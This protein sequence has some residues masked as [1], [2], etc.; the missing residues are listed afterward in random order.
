MLPDRSK[1]YAGVDGEIPRLHLATNW[2]L[3]GVA[4]LVLVFLAAIFPRQALLERLYQ[5]H[6]LDDLTLSYV[7][8]FYRTERGNADTI[9]LLARA[10]PESLDGT[11][12]ELALTEL[13]LSGD[14][15]QRNEAR[16]ILFAKY[17]QRKASAAAEPQKAQ[18]KGQ[19]KRLL[20]TAVRDPLP[21]DL[22]Q[23]FADESFALDLPELGVVYIR[24]M[25]NA[26]VADILKQHGDLALA[27][28]RHALAARYY[29]LARHQ[30]ASLEQARPLFEAAVKTLMAAS[31]YGQAMRDAQNHLGNLSE[32]PQTLRFLAHTALAAG[33]PGAAAQF[34][35]RLVFR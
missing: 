23:L 14:M 19:L 27:A 12:L 8:N 10:R 35:R 13:T 7:Q 11:A 29:F 5:Q 22:L 26:P 33:D 15:R 24:Q 31:L 9:L 21:G 16:G 32:D 2:Q 25:A 3:V 30:V 18:A 28:G 1:R 17:Q 4:L 34:S 6:Q 20:E